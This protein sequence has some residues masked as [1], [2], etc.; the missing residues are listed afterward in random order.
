MQPNVMDL[1]QLCL[2][3][4]IYIQTH[5][6]PDPDAIASAFGL[7]KLL[8][9][10]QITSTICYYGKIDK[11][12]TRKMTALLNINMESYHSLSDKLT[13]EDFIIC[14]D[15]QKGGG[16]ILD[17]TGT[18]IAC[19]DH[20]PN[21]SDAVYQY[22]DIC[23]AG[24]C[25][26]LIT[27]YYKDLQIEPDKTTAAA[28]LY[29]LKMDTS[30][31]TRGTTLLDIQM[32]EYLFGLADP[33]LMSDLEHSNMEFADLRAYGAA[34]E[35]IQLHGKVGFAS[36]PFACPHALTA[37]VSDFLLSL[38][39]VDIAVVY[40]YMDDGIKFS[41]RTENGLIHAGEIVH[42]ALKGIGNGGGHAF[43]AGGYIAEDS[44]PLLGN[45]PDT[46]IRELFLAVIDPAFS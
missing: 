44:V 10:F 25:A 6:F 11:F 37:A 30:D 21:C 36:I 45:F 29:G 23:I 22:C 14:V 12:S 15:S 40:S 26:S 42:N 7:Q 31:F 46:K 5:D 19:I 43:M 38:E 35:N 16:N 20:H 3:R 41:I 24:S 4:H 33:D 8:E 17:F 28:L 27:R 32:F 13:E 2:G 34:I 39:E 1:V 18:E 9:H